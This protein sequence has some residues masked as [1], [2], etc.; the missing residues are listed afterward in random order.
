MVL[1]HAPEAMDD[2]TQEAVAD[3]SGMEEFIWKGFQVL[4]EEMVVVIGGD[5][6]NFTKTETQTEI[7]ATITHP[8]VRYVAKWAI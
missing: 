1:L 6:M 8:D 5:L 2:S 4:V 7:E 3:S